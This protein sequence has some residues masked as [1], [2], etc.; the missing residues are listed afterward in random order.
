MNTSPVIS[1]REFTFE[2]P[3]ELYRTIRR[4][5]FSRHM[6]RPCL[7]FLPIGIIGLLGVF[8]SFYR[9][10][11]GGAFWLLIGISILP[12]ATWAIHNWSVSQIRAAGPAPRYTVRVEPESLTVK[13]EKA[14]STLKWSAISTIWKYPDMIFIF[15][16]KK[17]NINHA[18]VLPTASLGEDLSR[19]IENRVREHGGVVA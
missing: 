5:H 17:T 12:F 11:S 1:P 3:V 7:G 6:R 8:A 2:K 18:I 10:G 19:F 4:R 15:W 9:G 13:T 16:D 14:S